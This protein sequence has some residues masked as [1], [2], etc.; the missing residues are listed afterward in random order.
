MHIQKYVY[1]HC[2]VL[3]GTLLAICLGHS[4]V[5]ACGYSW[6]TKHT[7]PAAIYACMCDIYGEHISKKTTVR[8]C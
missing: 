3:L 7:T 8:D 2:S 5:C 1:T 4:R 6:D